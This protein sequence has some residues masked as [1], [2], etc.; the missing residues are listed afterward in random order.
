MT[1]TRVCC[2]NFE[3]AVVKTLSLWDAR[4][5]E[6]PRYLEMQKRVTTK[7]VDGKSPQL[8]GRRDNNSSK[9]SVLACERKCGYTKIQVI[10]ES[11]LSDTLPT[12]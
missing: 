4:T 11:A 9:S 12:R 5:T 8:T 7:R 1:M 2:T 6:H 10:D 3:C